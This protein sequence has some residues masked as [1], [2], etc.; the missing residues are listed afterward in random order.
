MKKSIIII[1][2]SSI[3]LLLIIYIVND[4][5]ITKESKSPN[6]ELNSIK[7]K[8]AETIDKL[9]KIKIPITIS[10]RLNRIKKG[11]CNYTFRYKLGIDSSEHYHHI[12]KNIK[13]ILNT[14]DTIAVIEIEAS[15]DETIDVELESLPDN[16]FE[17]LLSLRNNKSYFTAPSIVKI[18]EG[19]SKLR[20]KIS[21]NGRM[22]LVKGRCILPEKYK[23]IDGVAP[24]D[25]YLRNLKHLTG[26]KITKKDIENSPYL[27]KR[28]EKNPHLLSNS[29]RLPIGF[30]ATTILYEE[31]RP[32]VFDK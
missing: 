30:S 2:L 32:E 31:M 7:D 8:K 15:A 13:S 9:E 14:S 19:K 16:I 18:L 1:V 26:D 20:Y 4:K 29:I 25:Y 17:L 24:D 21:E 3:V 11:Y 5:I 12:K 27:Q 23:I 28:L 6:D 22:S 10:I